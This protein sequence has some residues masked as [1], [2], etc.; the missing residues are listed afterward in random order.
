M[1][2]KSIALSSLKGFAFCDPAPAGLGSL[3]A[4][5]KLDRGHSTKAGRPICC[6]GEKNSC[7]GYVDENIKMTLQVKTAGGLEMSI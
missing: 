2:V 6:G 3:S 1:I 7:G 5:E 4:G